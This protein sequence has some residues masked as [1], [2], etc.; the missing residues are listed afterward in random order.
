MI[1]FQGG[2]QIKVEP[3]PQEVLNQLGQFGGAVAQFVTANGKTA[4]VNPSHIDYV[5][6][7][8]RSGAA[9]T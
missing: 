7:D 8:D 4:I 3:E 5:V 1:H 6:A 9:F 2:Q